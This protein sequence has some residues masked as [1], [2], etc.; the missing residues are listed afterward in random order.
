M[1]LLFLNNVLIAFLHAASVQEFQET[2]PG[3]SVAEEG[4][5]M[6]CGV[7]LELHL[8]V[9]G[10]IRTGWGGMVQSRVSADSSTAAEK[11]I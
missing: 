1:L 6:G 4:H 5:G 9:D 7:V 8:E 10:A 11:S 3:C 2:E